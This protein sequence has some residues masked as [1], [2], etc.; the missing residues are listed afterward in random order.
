MKNIFNTSGLEQNKEVF[1][2]LVEK[3]NFRIERIVSNGSV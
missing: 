1:E 3:N 2:T